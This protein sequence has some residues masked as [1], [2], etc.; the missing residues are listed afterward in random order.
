[1]SRA[2]LIPRRRFLA[3]PGLLGA[4]TLAGTAW[5]A[6]AKGR[7]WLG[8]ELAKA[9]GGVLA[10]RVMRN[11]P[12]EKGGLKTGDVLLDIDGRAVAAVGDV[13][14]LV[15]EKGPGVTIK[16]RARRAT[17]DVTVSV[18]LVEFP[19]EEEVLRLDKVGT[20]APEWK[21]VKSAQ[22]D[23][24]EIKKLRGRVVLVDFWASWCV[25]C[26]LTTPVLN[27]LFTKLG[28]QGLTVVGLTDDA[29]EAA[30]KAIAKLG[31]KYPVCSA[32]SAETFSAYGVR[33]LPT[34]FLVDKRGVFREVVIG[35]QPVSV[36]EKTI[37]KLLKESAPS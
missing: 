29:E 33:S 1:M 32:T 21:G 24:T 34:F 16:V 31:I 18:A 37:T 4:S 2:W 5:A 14:R 15:G 11:S 8:V 10:K 6:P 28:P 23:V 9:E 13:V 36:F 20:F 7:A 25:A 30:L 27:D 19:G 12:A 3:L 35:A 26:R 17:D 22:G